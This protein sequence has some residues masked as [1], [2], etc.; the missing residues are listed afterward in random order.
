MRRSS[1]GQIEMNE[2]LLV[3]F[4][5]VLIIA[6][7]SLLYYRHFMETAKTQVEELSEQEMSVLLASITE[8]GEIRCGQGDCIDTSKIIPF[9]NVIKAHS[10]Y[11]NADLGFKKIT[12]EIVYPASEHNKA[13]CDLRAYQ[14][15]MYPNN[16]GFYTLY[17]N[18]PKQAKKAITVGS[19]VS[20]YYPETD[21]YRIGR[22]KIESYA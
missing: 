14:Q 4:F 11:Y 19:P 10:A 20:I 16:C 5:I 7:G 9:S 22:L 13:P 6:I 15:S 1:K 21:E 2:T 18:E 17:E 8:M 3:V 12:L